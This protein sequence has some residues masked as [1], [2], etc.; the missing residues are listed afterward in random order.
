MG[1][2][3]TLPFGSACPLGF[4]FYFAD[5]SGPF[6][7]YNLLWAETLQ[8]CFSSAR[9]VVFHFLFV[10]RPLSCIQIFVFLFIIH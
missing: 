3:L 5:A 6:V 4:R 2:L 10:L 8:S 1:D 7:S 9:L